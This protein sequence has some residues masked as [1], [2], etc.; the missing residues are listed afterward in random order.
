MELHLLWAAI[1]AISAIIYTILDGFDLGV[2]IL[3]P[4]I[5]NGYQRNAMVNS[6]IPVWDG[7][8]TWV[9]LMALSLFGGFPTAYS[10]LLPA[11]YIPLVLM[12]FSLIMRGI[13]MEFRFQSQHRKGLWDAAFAGGSALAA[14]CQGVVLG[15]LMEGIRFDRTVP[16]HDISFNFFSP[17]TMMTGL[18]LVIVYALSGATWLN[19]KTEGGLQQSVRKFAKILVILLTLSFLI[20]L[21]GRFNFSSFQPRFGVFGIAK[22]TAVTSIIWCVLSALLLAAVLFNLKNKRDWIPFGLSITMVLISA[23]YIVTGFWPYIV[24][25]DV[26]VYDAGISPNASKVLLYSAYFIVPILLI[27]LIYSYTVFRGKVSGNDK[28]EPE[29]VND[30]LNSVPAANEG[31]LAVAKAIRLPWIIYLL[32]SVLGLVY[33]F[34]VLGFLGEN[35]S[36]VAIVIF[37][38]VFLGATLYFKK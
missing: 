19:W 35:V 7:N 30:K 11:L 24:P 27:N 28:Y 9:V 17:F 10:I 34:I 38:I 21:Y 12:V 20:I 8:E 18:T 36:I 16:F 25:P 2:G 14:F 33:F 3:F 23:I 1:I 31:D 37:I 15:N 22:T 5:R 29:L 26:T 13:A 32:I 4:F 6:I